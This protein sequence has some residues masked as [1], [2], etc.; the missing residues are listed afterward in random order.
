MRTKAFRSITYLNESLLDD[1]EADEVVDNDKPAAE[2]EFIFYFN[3]D[4]S[5]EIVIDTFFGSVMEPALNRMKSSGILDSWDFNRENGR[6]NDFPLIDLFTYCMYNTSASSS[7]MPAFVLSLAVMFPEQEESTEFLG[8]VSAVLMQ[9]ALASGISMDGNMME[10]FRRAGDN[11]VYCVFYEI[12]KNAMPSVCGEKWVFHCGR[13][14]ANSLDLCEK[15]AGCFVKK[16]GKLG[17]MKPVDDAGTRYVAYSFGKDAGNQMMYFIASD[18][19]CLNEFTVVLSAAAHGRFLGNG[20]MYVDFSGRYKNYLRMDGTTWQD[21]GYMCD[22]AFSGGFVSVMRTGADGHAEGNLL[23]KDGDPLLDEWC[24]RT[25]RFVDGLA[26]VV[27]ET[28]SEWRN[29]RK[30]NVV[31]TEGH[32]L[33]REWYD[34]IKFEDTDGEPDAGCKRTVA[35]V[36]KSGSESPSTFIWNYVDRTGKLL[37]KEW[38]NGHCSCMKNGFAEL[39]KITV[40]GDT[41]YNYMREDG[42]LVSEE[43]FYSVCG[44][45]E[46]GVFAFSKDG[47][48]QF[49][50]TESGNVMFDGCKFSSVSQIKASDGFRHYVVRMFDG[51][52]Y[53]KK[54]YCNL[55]SSDG[56]MCCGKTD[57]WEVDYVGNGL[58]LASKSFRSKKEILKFG[59]GPV[60]LGRVVSHACRLGDSEY[61]VVTSVDKYAVID[62]DGKPVSDE[63]FDR[64]GD[65]ICGG[66]VE[67][68][69]YGTG[70]YIEKRMNILSCRTG[71]LLFGTGETLPCRICGAVPGKVA[72]VE[73]QDSVLK[74][75]IFD[76]NGNM[77]LD[78]WTGFR[79]SA[80][81]DGGLLKVGPNSYVDCS[82]KPVSL[83]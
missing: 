55:V 64:I 2:Y 32:L 29:E 44:W 9:Y 50:D 82:G 62:K 10:A 48:W 54:Q 61:A 81:D 51:D 58:V 49:M 52:G 31:D 20:L 12:A 69:S 75:S 41:V 36:R 1:V 71:K 17:I 74:Y 65:N 14:C 38:F 39:N 79:I 47:M 59:K 25:E 43:W 7:D 18:G 67:V 70:R 24:K 33:F 15:F 66:F 4:K 23:D 56:V 83:I 34:D 13:D 5:P 6:V 77:L 57:M 78:E 76:C 80:T 45:P 73:K 37:S 8:T 3:S 63:W 11:L 21:L 27:K 46:D 26:I 40:D 60:E 30:H 72:V 28:R 22:S 53:D 42:S 68:W 16:A 35:R 19:T